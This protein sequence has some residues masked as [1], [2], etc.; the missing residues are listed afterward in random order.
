MERATHG[1]KQYKG[2][3]RKEEEKLQ[4]FVRR[5]QAC[6]LRMENGDVDERMEI[7]WGQDK[8]GDQQQKKGGIECRMEMGMEEK[9]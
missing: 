5:A 1:T 4:R 2:K 3:E 6:R 8:D 9:W 7:V